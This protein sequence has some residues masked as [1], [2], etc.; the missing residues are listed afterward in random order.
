MPNNIPAKM[1]DNM[2]GAMYWNIMNDDCIW[3]KNRINYLKGRVN[4]G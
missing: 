1:R 4:N 3:L 2:C